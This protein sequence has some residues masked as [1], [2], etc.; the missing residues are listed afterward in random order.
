MSLKVVWARFLRVAVEPDEVGAAGICLRLPLVEGRD[1]RWVGGIL[2]DKE[3]RDG[4]VASSQDM[5]LKN[6]ESRRAV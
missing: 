5:L 6:L 1:W 3:T 2:G 4:S